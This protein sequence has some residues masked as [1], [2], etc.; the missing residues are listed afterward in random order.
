MFQLKS[1]PENGYYFKRD[2]GIYNISNNHICK[3]P[4]YNA[5]KDGVDTP[6]Y[7]IGNE[8]LK[9]FDT[10]DC[11]IGY[12]LGISAISN[13]SSFIGAVTMSFLNGFIGMAFAIASLFF[14]FSLLSVAIKILSI[15][16]MCLI[17][18]S[19]LI[20]VSPITITCILFGRT[21]DIFNAWF[22]ALVSYS[23]QPA[24]IFIFACLFI[25]IFNHTIVKED[26]RF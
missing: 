2:S 19:M 5:K 22:S 10:L 3:F 8:Y 4:R 23:I 24:L 16:V 6:S 7:P 25:S 13:G 17:Y 12:S 18:I 26:V 1:K 21:K 20:Y 11:M 15:F 14:A 9:V